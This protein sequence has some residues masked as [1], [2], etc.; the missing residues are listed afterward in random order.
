MTTTAI[1]SAALVL[2]DLLALIEDEGNRIERV[3]LGATG[4]AT[5]HVSG[6]VPRLLVHLGIDVPDEQQA[7][8]DDSVWRVVH[9]GVRIDLWGA[10]HDPVPCEHL[11]GGSWHVDPEPSEACGADSIPG[12]DYCPAHIEEH[13]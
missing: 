3:T 2:A 1:P 9:A 8:E 7:T 13:A 12:H 4:A 10:S 6:D 5:V 11:T